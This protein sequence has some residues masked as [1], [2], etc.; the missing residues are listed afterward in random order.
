MKF[1]SRVGTPRT[2]VIAR[3]SDVLERCHEAVVHVQLLMT[4]KQGQ[5]GIVGDE[6]NLY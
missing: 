2:P 3:K 4:V 6:V 1:L 5:A